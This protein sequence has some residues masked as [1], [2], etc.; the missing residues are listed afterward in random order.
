MITRRHLLGALAAGICAS[1][2]SAHS[3]YRQWLVYR[4]KHLLIGCHRKDLRTYGLAQEIVEAVNHA[5]PEAKSRV[6]RA[7][8]PERLASLLGTDQMELAVIGVETAA[9]MKAGRGRFAPY[10]RIDLSA[11]GA[12]DGYVLAAEVSFSAQHGWIVAAAL[13]EAGLGGAGW[14]QTVL[15]QHPGA[16]AFRSGVGIEDLETLE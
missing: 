11:L 10:G 7:P 14:D 1:Q 8:R 16:R 13:D 6:A 4:R 9:E 5:A 12:F 15:A 3:L 2:A